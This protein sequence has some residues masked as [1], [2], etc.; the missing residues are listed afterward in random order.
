MG[1]DVD[2]L[3]VAL[4]LGD[5]A[6]L[7]L[8]FDV[9]DLFTGLGHDVLLDGRDVHVGDRDGQPR[10]GGEVVAHLLELIEQDDR[11][12]MAELLVAA[13]DDLG[14]LL[15][16]LR[17]V[18]VAQ[19][20]RD[21]LVEEDAADGGMILPRG[22]VEPLGMLA[23]AVGLGDG[24]QAADLDAGVQVDLAIGVSGDDLGAVGEDHAFPLLAE[25]VL[26]QVMQTKDHVVRRHRDRLAGGRGEDVVGSHLQDARFQLSLL[27]QGHVDG[28]LVAIEVGVE[29]RAGQ[30]CS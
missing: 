21:D 3:V 26:G 12:I 20:L 7:G 13:L 18:D 11:A 30:G 9:A 29:G 6:V 10:H 19:L 24:G 23:V 8:A 4:G 1:P 14:E 5:D 27:G 15:L 28:H 22:D 16:A 25:L 2:D 17:R